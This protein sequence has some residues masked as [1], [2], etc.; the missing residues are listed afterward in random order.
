MSLKA[1]NSY[2][3]VNR[4]IEK[5]STMVYKLAFARTRNEIDAEDIFQEVFLRY[6]KKKPVFESDEH[7]KAWFIRVT[8][9]CSKTLWKN[10]FK[11]N[12]ILKEEIVFE[13]KTE[14]EAL[15]EEHLLKL[16]TD[17]RIVIHLFYYED[18]KTSDIAKVLNKKESTIRMQL[19]RA[20]RLLK[21]F[22]EG[23]I[24]DV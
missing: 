17:Y 24:V 23:E 19:T 8:I 22:M 13:E 15:L 1:F 16:P 4:I 14:E 18:M 20:R 7:E 11:H 10:I 9:N 21:D 2:E 3:D 12:E 6:V 5:Y